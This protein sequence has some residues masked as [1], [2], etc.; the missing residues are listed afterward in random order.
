M[1]DGARLLTFT[2]SSSG[3]KTAVAQL[4]RRHANHL[5]AQ[6]SERPLIKLGVDSYLHP[7]RS[8][9][10]IKVPDFAPAGYIKKAQYDALLVEVG[11]IEAS[12]Q[13]T[14]QTKLPANEFGAEVEDPAADMSDVLDDEIP[15]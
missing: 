11:L 13:T 8:Y 15:F 1:L 10:R 14:T 2:T 4:S 3:G 7:N 9:G 12:E 5:R 6:P